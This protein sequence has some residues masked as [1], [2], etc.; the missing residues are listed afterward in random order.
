M[1]NPHWARPTLRSRLGRG[2]RI[3]SVVVHMVRST[4]WRKCMGAPIVKPLDRTKMQLSL[5]DRTPVDMPFVTGHRLLVAH[6]PHRAPAA[7]A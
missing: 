6:L 2:E 1:H 5:K 3:I 4:A 7:T